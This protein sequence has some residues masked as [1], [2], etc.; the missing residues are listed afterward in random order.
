M[1]PY[2]RTH[3]RPAVSVARHL[4]DELA[5]VVAVSL[6]EGA[7]R[8]PADPDAHL[9]AGLLLAMWTV[10]F[11]EAHR[12]FRQTRDTKEANAVFLAIVDRGT[13]GLKAAMAGGPYA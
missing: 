6:S 9:A 4:S 7:G 8:D 10:A 13:V 5:Q 12:S 1:I 2:G 11:I 3:R